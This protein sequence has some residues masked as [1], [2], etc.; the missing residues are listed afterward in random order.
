MA[1]NQNPVFTDNSTLTGDGTEENPLAAVGG[2]ASP[3]GSEGDAQF[4]DGSGGFTNA[5]GINADAVVNIGGGGTIVIKAPDSTALI[6]RAPNGNL[7]IGTQFEGC[8]IGIGNTSTGCFLDFFQSGTGAPKQ[9]VTGSR[10]DG[11]ALTSL[12][13]A[14]AAYG[15]ITDNSTP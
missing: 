8:L 9:T 5:A 13:T 14:L 4:N 2:G 10:T 6:L 11:T 7:L 1:E 3:G 12:L 15:L